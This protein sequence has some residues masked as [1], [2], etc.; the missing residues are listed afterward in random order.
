MLKDDHE[1]LTNL[2]WKKISDITLSCIIAT[3]NI[4]NNS[5]EWK[6]PHHVERIRYKGIMVNIENQYIDMCTTINHKVVVKENLD[7]I[8]NKKINV[9]G[10]LDNKYLIKS[11]EPLIKNNSASTYKT[12]YDNAKPNISVFKLPSADEVFNNA[13]FMPKTMSMESWL[14]FLALYIVYGSLSDV[15]SIIIFRIN[16][17]HLINKLLTF[18]D[19]VGTKLEYSEVNDIHY[20]YNT[21]LYKYLKPFGDLKN[22]SVPPYIYNLSAFQSLYLLKILTN[23]NESELRSGTIF[24]TKLKILA[25]TIQILAINSDFSAYIS[26]NFAN[27]LNILYTIHIKCNDGSNPV[28]SNDHISTFNMKCT[29]IDL[30][31]PNNIFMARRNGLACW[32]S[33]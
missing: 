10:L 1:V 7:D 11:I 6:S 22:R 14:K 23:Y 18:Q 12:N 3:H 29:V 31:V 4:Q 26:T 33:N 9:Y 8:V 5:L 13:T 19:I 32:T 21:N 2:G 25:D 28:V 24:E 20:M 16:E 15:T 17:I 30:I 27:D